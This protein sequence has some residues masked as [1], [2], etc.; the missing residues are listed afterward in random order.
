MKFEFSREK[1]VKFSNIKFH[2][3]SSSGSQTVPRGQTDGQK[4]MTNTIVVFRNSG[5]AHKTCYDYEFVGCD[6]SHFRR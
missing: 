5:N 3:N 4:D 1:F 2:G 6:I